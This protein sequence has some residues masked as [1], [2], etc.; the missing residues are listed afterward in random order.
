MSGLMMMILTACGQTESSASTQTGNKTLVAYFS[1]TG[2]TKHLAE[3][4]AQVLNADL[5]EIKPTQPY[6][7]ADLDW[8]NKSSRTTIEMN[9]DKSRPAIAEKVE[10]FSQYD[11]VV[12]AYPIWWSQAPRIV[13]TFVESYDFSGKTVTAVC[14]SGGSELG[15]SAKYLQSLNSKS[16]KWLEG[17]RFNSFATANEINDWLKSINFK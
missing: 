3:T 12:I 8:H 7:T 14:T 4:I 10:N 16:A 9:D 15:S 6:T 1:A 13:D 17:R 5:F 11:K 2:N